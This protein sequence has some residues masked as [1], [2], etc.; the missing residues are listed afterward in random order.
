VLHFATTFCDKSRNA[1]YAS[2]VRT[3]TIQRIKREF[4]YRHHLQESD[5]RT[6]MRSLACYDTVKALAARPLTS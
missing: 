2:T 1:D 5:Q 4:D 6:V 3:A